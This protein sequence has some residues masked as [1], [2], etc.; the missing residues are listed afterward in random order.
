MPAGALRIQPGTNYT[1]AAVRL[2]QGAKR[3]TDE[4]DLDRAE[5]LY[6]EM[7]KQ[8]REVGEALLGLGRIHLRRGRFDTALILFRASL[9]ADPNR[10]APYAA[11]G[12]ALQAMRRFAEALAVYEQ[13]LQI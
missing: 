6:N 5:R 1:G 11:T 13:G 4:G 10:P 7:L 9:A 2:L 12:T 8:S 3:A